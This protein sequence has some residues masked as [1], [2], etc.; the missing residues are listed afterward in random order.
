MDLVTVLERL[1][2]SV[3]RYP[4]QYAIA[5]ERQPALAP[6]PTALSALSAL[7]ELARFDADTR[8]DLVL[9]IVHEQQIA[10]HP[11]WQAMLV[12]AFAPVL[13]RLRKRLGPSPSGALDQ[14]VVIHFLEALHALPKAPKPAPTPRAVWRRAARRAFVEGTFGRFE[15]RVVPID[16][17]TLPLEPFATAI[18][19][20][21]L[22]ASAAEIEELVE[23]GGCAEEVLAVLLAT[24]ASEPKLRAF[25]N[26]S[27]F[28]EPS[29]RRERD[30]GRLTRARR[31]L[32]DRLR[33]R[34]QSLP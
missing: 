17:E 30:L 24:Y 22:D 1:R 6:Y 19:E 11:L 4:T 3:P 33:Q 18:Q 21:L 7:A 29:S 34:H 27:L 14:E 23:L 15:K 26:R 5:R 25:V 8:A 28:A 13:R 32:R 31:R 2:G 16:E 9:A 20:G 10:P 12:S